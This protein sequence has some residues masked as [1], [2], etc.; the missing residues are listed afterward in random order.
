MK[1]PFIMIVVGMTVCGKTNYMLEMLERDHMKHFENIILLCPTFEWN[2][3]CHEW[4]N[5]DDPD[6]LAIPCDQDDVNL[7]LKHVVDLFKGSNCLIILDDCAS[8][9]TSKTARSM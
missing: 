7:G 1:T 5:R 6:F 3:T 8:G 2:K 9:K 4:K